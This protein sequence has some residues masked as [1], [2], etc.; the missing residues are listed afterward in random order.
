MNKK[1]SLLLQK[2]DTITIQHQNEILGRLKLFKLSKDAI[3]FFCD[4]RYKAMEDYD[5]KGFK[6]DFKLVGFQ[7]DK[8]IKKIKYKE[9]IDKGRGFIQNELSDSIF[10]LNMSTFENW[11]STILKIEYL[12][13]KKGFLK[14]FANDR[15]KDKILNL[16]ILEESASLEE[17]W[18]IIINEYLRN[19]R[20]IKKAINKLL[21]VLNV[22]RKSLTHNIIE[23]INENSLCRNVIVHN[24]KKI[25]D[26]YI[27]KSGKFAKFK[28]SESITITE[29]ILF[30]Q[31]DNLL[32]FMQDLKK[33][34]RLR[35]N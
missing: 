28:K 2:I 21:E 24:Q 7:K 10:V 9:I 4:S 20:G 22:E 26:N 35:L 15:D 25:E 12:D 23:K 17:V 34:I 16:S 13:D 19:I 31:G 11:M 32:R 8:E 14:A 1:D 5:F 3:Y 29:E 27:K 18:E 6:E 30:Q 33:Q